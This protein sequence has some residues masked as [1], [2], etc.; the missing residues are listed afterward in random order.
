MG[1]DYCW[2]QQ[3]G[4]KPECVAYSDDILEI[5]IGN[6]IIRTHCLALALNKT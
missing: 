1:T 3:G 2:R 6:K 5:K 4:C